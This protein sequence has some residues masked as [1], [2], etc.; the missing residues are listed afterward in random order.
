MKNKWHTGT[1]FIKG[2]KYQWSYKHSSCVKCRKVDFPHKG[3][4]LCSKCYDKKRDENPERQLIKEKARKKWFKANYE[5]I[6]KAKETST[7][8]DKAYKKK[9]YWENHWKYL[10]AKKL[11]KEWAKKNLQW[12]ECIKFRHNDE[13]YY[14]PYETF[15][16]DYWT[17][18]RQKDLKLCKEWLDKNN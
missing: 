8:D 12:I 13:Y 16:K 9:W 4:G 6:K 18:T 5:Y 1:L 17:A 14:L 2:W 10:K 11:L 15:Q 7:F 3:K